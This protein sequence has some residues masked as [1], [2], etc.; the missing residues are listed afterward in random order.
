MIVD[1]DLRVRRCAAG[2]SSIDESNKSRQ[3]IDHSRASMITP[4]SSMYLPCYFSRYLK[5][6]TITTTYMFKVAR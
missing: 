6:V 3:F 4:S 1:T 5:L 2:Q